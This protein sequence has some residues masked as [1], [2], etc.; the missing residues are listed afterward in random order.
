MLRAYQRD[1]E[2]AT[3]AMIE[4]E[5][6]DQ[7]LLEQAARLLEANS[8]EAFAD[9]RSYRY[10]VPSPARYLFQW[11]WDSCFHAIVWAAVDVARARDE[12]RSLVARQ[13]GAGLLPHI[14]YWQSD[15]IKR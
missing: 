10:T 1:D 8:R 13:K 6:R 9:G 7:P 12:L 14:N 2:R 5:P 3:L 4:N 15:L 11:H